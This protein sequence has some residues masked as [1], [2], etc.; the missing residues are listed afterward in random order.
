MNRIDPTSPHESGIDINGNVARL[1]EFDSDG[2]FVGYIDSKG[3]CWESR[4]ERDEAI[5]AARAMEAFIE[6]N[7]FGGFGPAPD[8]IDIFEKHDILEENYVYV[9]IDL[10]RSLKI[11][12]ALAMRRAV[13]A[14]FN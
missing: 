8:L 2:V 14:A 11:Y 10:N 1:G 12:S 6:W 3:N 7:R 13:M 9:I 5:G 4:R